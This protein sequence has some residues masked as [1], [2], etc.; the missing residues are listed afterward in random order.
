MVTKIHSRFS[1]V[2][3]LTVIAAMI[4]IT[5]PQITGKT[6]FEQFKP[7]AE[8]SEHIFKGGGFELYSSNIQ[9]VDDTTWSI[10][11]Q[12]KITRWIKIIDR[13]FNVEVQVWDC[14]DEQYS[15]AY[16]SNNRINADGLF[17]LKANFTTPTAGKLRILLHSSGSSID[18]AYNLRTG[19]MIRGWDSKLM[20]GIKEV[21][22]CSA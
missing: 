2:V 9:K 13:S 3:L 12:G 20:K 19:Q 16:Q 18:T 14:P 11:L 22:V 10:E 6:V 15:V 5:Y 4:F 21:D 8:I 1:I 7:S 17:T